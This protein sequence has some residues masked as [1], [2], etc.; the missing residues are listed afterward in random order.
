MMPWF[1]SSNLET[2]PDA[3][4]LALLLRFL[5]GAVMSGS[6]IHVLFSEKKHFII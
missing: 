2:V 3:S 5:F 4:A 1:H 6:C